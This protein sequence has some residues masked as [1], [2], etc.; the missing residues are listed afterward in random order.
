MDLAW[1]PG[2]Q[3]FLH[4]GQS[5]ADGATVHQLR[6]PEAPPMGTHPPIPDP[7]VTVVTIPD[8]SFKMRGL[9]SPSLKRQKMD[10]SPAV[11]GHSFCVALLPFIPFFFPLLLLEK[12]LCGSRPGVTVH[13]IRNAFSCQQASDTAGTTGVCAS[14]RD[15]RARH[16]PT[17]ADPGSPSCQRFSTLSSS[18]AVRGAVTPSSQCEK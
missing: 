14:W 18:P 12:S 13:I 9:T 15:E 16:Q 1:E 2:P 17:P 11:L 4:R 5:P 6:L 3:A 10:D 8:Y 7:A